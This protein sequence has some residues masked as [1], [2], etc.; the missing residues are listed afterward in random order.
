MERDFCLYSSDNDQKETYELNSF[1]AGTLILTDKGKIPIDRINIGQKVNTKNPLSNQEFLEKVTSIN[2]SH[3]TNLYSLIVDNVEI[4]CTE[5]HLFWV[6]DKGWTKAK[7]TLI[8][9]KLI[10]RDGSPLEINKVEKCNEENIVYDFTING[11]STYF[12]SE[13]EIHTHSGSSKSAQ[14][15]LVVNL[16]TDFKSQHLY[17][18]NKFILIDK[19]CMKHILERHHPLYYNSEL[20]RSKN[21]FLNQDL[22]VM[23]IMNIIKGVLDQ[24]RTELTKKGGNGMYQISGTVNGVKYILGI[25]NGRVGQLYPLY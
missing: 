13:L 6:K 10:S 14:P 11:Y 16:L 12:V 21:S 25:N 7:Q 17:Y 23:N 5:N 24:N 4:K 20:G 2:Q 8:G 18:G 15:H 3:S 9:D 19:R 1:V 22:T